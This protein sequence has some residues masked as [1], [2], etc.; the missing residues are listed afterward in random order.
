ME[1]TLQHVAL[2][3]WLAG[4]VLQERAA[5]GGRRGPRRGV[6]GG[7]CSSVFWKETE[8][9]GVQEVGVQTDLVLTSREV[10][11]QTDCVE[12]TRSPAALTSE[13]EYEAKIAFFEVKAEGLSRKA[14]AR[15]SAS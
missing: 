6:L 5:A 4:G 14:Q 2:D 7:Q 9:R 8:N 12:I 10:G 3:V 13:F 1:R 15:Q 11:V